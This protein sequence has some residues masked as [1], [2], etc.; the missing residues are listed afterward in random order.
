MGKD[1]FPQIYKK[2]KQERGGKL[3]VKISTYSDRYSPNENYAGLI[4]YHKND[5]HTW[6]NTRGRADGHRGR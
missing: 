2:A 6:K 1:N 5:Q 3:T 4:I